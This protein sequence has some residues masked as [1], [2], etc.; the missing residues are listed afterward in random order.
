M[1]NKKLMWGVIFSA[2]IISAG[3]KIIGGY[4]DVNFSRVILILI[5]AMLFIEGIK[6]VDFF[7]ILFPVAVLAIAYD[8]ELGITAIIPGPLLLV[9]FFLCV[10]L[11][12]I[13][14]D[15]S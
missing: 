6:R 1:G 13:F 5:A 12:R 7:R 15:R 8:R 11:G 2:L 10:V 14:R 4:Q 9:T 3:L